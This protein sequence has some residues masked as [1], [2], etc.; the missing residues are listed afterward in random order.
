MGI[1]KFGNNVK[2]LALAVISGREKY[3]LRGRCNFI[4]GGECLI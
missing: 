1:L 2:V 4:R 3:G